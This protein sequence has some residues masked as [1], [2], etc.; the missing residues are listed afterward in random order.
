[1]PTLVEW[2]ERVKKV[3]VQATAD[4]TDDEVDDFIEYGH[5]ELDGGPLSDEDLEGFGDDED[6]EPEDSED[7]D[8][9]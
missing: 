8:D 2:K 3:I 1:M 7:E 5:E 4:L 9:L 6:E